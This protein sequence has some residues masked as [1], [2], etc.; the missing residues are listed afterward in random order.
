M[1]GPKRSVRV[2]EQLKVALAN[3][4]TREMSDPRLAGV[5]VSRVELTDDLG[6][7][8]A[9]VRMLSGGDDEKTRASTMRALER[10]SSMIRRELGARVKMRVVPQV[11]FFYDAG[12]DRQARVEEL[13]HEIATERKR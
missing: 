6:L 12:Q 8:T 3:L 2:G 13:L 7:L 1:P 10:A 5:I 4:L 11:R 9:H